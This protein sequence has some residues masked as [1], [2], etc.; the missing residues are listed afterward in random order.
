MNIQSAFTRLLVCDFKACFLFYRDVLEFEVIVD[1]GNDG[2]AE[3]K[4][5][6]MRLSLFNRQEMAEIVGNQLPSQAE[7]QDKVAL[8][9]MVPDLDKA[10]QQLRHKNVKF[11]TE[12]LT[13]PYYGI[14]TVYFRDPD[15]TLIGLFQA[16]V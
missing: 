13:K 9:F 15:G 2:Y 11:T 12:P 7:S 6:N 10:C 14:K 8:I 1:A 3:F 5:G 16:L 4:A